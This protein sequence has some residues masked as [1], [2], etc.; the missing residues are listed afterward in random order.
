[1]VPGARRSSGKCSLT[2]RHSSR[3]ARVRIRRR[4]RRLGRGRGASS[5][6]RMRVT[7][8]LTVVSLTKSAWAISPLESPRARSLRTS[9]SR[10]VSS[11]EVGG[12]AGGGW[13]PAANCSISRRVMRG[14]EQG[15]ACRDDADGGGELL[16]ADVLEE[17]AAGAGPQGLVDVLVEVEGGEDEDVGGRR[18][19]SEPAGGLDAVELGHA[20]VHEDDVGLVLA[21]A[22]DRFGGRRR[23]RRR[24]RCR[25]RPRGSCGSRRGRAAGRRRSGPGAALSSACTRSPRRWR[26]GSPR[27]SPGGWSGI[28]ELVAASARLAPAIAGLD[29]VAL[30]LSTEDQRPQSVAQRVR[31]AFPDVLRAHAARA[32]AGR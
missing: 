11:D 10:A 18:R 25:V 31:D 24:P 32:R 12:C 22:G 4:A 29:G 7:W 23:P 1:M 19:C 8:V 6:V 5:F 14:C 2:P 3:P 28:D 27:A 9:S 16:G 13:R 30:A 26:G 15:V 20:D 21:G 17:E